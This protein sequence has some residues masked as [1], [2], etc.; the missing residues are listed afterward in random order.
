MIF[1]SHQSAHKR[2]LNGKSN[3]LSLRLAKRNFIEFKRKREFELRELFLK[4][5]G[6][7]ESTGS[8]KKAAAVKNRKRCLNCKC[9]ISSFCDV[10]N[11]YI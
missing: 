2:Q 3:Q 9:I 1:F 6:R 10:S 4:I 11:K 8:S 5:A 7:S